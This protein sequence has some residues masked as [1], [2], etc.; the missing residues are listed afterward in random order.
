[1]KNSGGEYTTDYVKLYNEYCKMR[2]L[3]ENTRISYNGVLRKLAAVNDLSVITIGEVYEFI[4]SGSLM[5]RTKQRYITTLR[6]FFQWMVD[7]GYRKDIPIGKI[8]VKLGDSIPKYLT[9]D[10]VKEINRYL[11]YK[12]NKRDY[13]MIN[14]LLSTGLRNEELRNLLWKHVDI[15]EGR[16]FVERG[17]GDK[18][19]FVY[20]GADVRNMFLNLKKN[21]K[22]TNGGDHVFTNLKGGEL[23]RSYMNWLTNDIT[24]STRIKVTPHMLRHTYATQSVAAGMPINVL[25]KQM[26]HVSPNTTYIYANTL[27]ETQRKHAVSGYASI[28]SRAPSGE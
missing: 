26:G 9:E 13:Y 8:S 15:D 19:R 10:E 22:Y 25:Q 4:N 7:M 17:K 2:N 23:S 18:D 6:S 14:I 3:S 1:M 16:L 21:S 27:D 12:K 20:F 11:R 28:G 24:S 5:P